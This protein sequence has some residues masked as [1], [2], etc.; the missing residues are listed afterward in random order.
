MQMSREQIGAGGKPSNGMFLPYTEL[1]GGAWGR[2]G[3]VKLNHV[4][5]P[6][7]QGG[8]EKSEILCWSKGLRARSSGLAAPRGWPVKLARLPQKL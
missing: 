6:L 4:T 5:R 7:R 8:T 2:F 1:C 3:A